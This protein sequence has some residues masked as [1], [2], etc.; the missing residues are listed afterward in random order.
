M[1]ASLA[2]FIMF[3]EALPKED[4]VKVTFLLTKPDFA[5]ESIYSALIG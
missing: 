1:T 5:R 2:I 3:R 4:I